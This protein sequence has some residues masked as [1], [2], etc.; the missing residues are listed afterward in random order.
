MNYRCILIVAVF[1]AFSSAYRFSAA[2]KSKAEQRTYPGAEPKTEQ[3]S[4][5]KPKSDALFKRLDLSSSSSFGFDTADFA[6][7]SA[8]TTCGIRA[9]FRDADLRFYEALTDIALPN[10]GGV[11]VRSPQY[12]AA[13][14]LTRVLPFPLAV[15][16]GTLSPGG[17]FSRLAAPAPSFSASPFVKS[18]PTKTGIASSLPSSSTGNKPPAFAAD[19]RLPDT[20]PRFAGSGASF[21]Y[22][23][24]GTLAAS[25]DIRLALPRMM[26]AAV[27]ITGASFFLKNDTSS[28]FSEIAF[29]KPARHSAFALQ[30]LFSAPNFTSLFTTGLYGQPSEKLR[31]TYRSEN[32]FTAGGFT[33]LA[34][35]FASDG[36]GIITPNGT[37]LHTLSQF[38]ISS[39]YTH[40]FPSPRLPS[41]TVGAAGTMRQTYTAFNDAEQTSA[42]C[43][44]G[45]QYSD[46][47]ISSRLAFEAGGIEFS[48]AQEVDADAV[49]YAISGDFFRRRG[50][51]RYGAQASYSFSKKAAEESCKFLLTHSKKNI[52]SSGSAGFSF[53]QK[54]GEYGGGTASIGFSVSH[55][56]KFIKYAFR[57]SAVG[58]Y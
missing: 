5:T 38:R 21:F 36:R 53:K 26:S 35:A 16:V 54:N 19:C 28:W 30:A 37:V 46:K 31:C 45:V 6:Q 58:K 7:T 24:D 57:L 41:L 50:T 40:R 17:S 56:T 27:S 1:A 20:A 52:T 39:Q 2:E 48:N 18:F 49:R 9:R 25:A 22:R 29:F 14:S 15:K 32:V 23:E 47:Y 42:K 13:L 51:L 43:G 55:T 8:D 4:G 33:L 10:F 12:G 34:S 44:A 3:K 11:S